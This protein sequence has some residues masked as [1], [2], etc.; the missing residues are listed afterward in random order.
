MY[1]SIKLFK[2]DILFHI[3]YISSNLYNFVEIN[4]TCKLISHFFFD[5]IIHFRKYYLQSSKISSSL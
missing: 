2:K 5:V 1:E 4:V 3:Y